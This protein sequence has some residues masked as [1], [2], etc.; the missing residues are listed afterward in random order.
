MSSSDEGVSPAEGVSPGE[1]ID[2]VKHPLIVSARDLT[3][4]PG[5]ERAGRCLADGARLI[6]NLLDAGDAVEAVLVPRGRNDQPAQQDLRAAAARAG[7]AVHE[8]RAGVLRHVLAGAAPP[9]AL[10]V[11]PLPRV[12]PGAVP[13]RRL[14]VVC[15]GVADPGN[16]GSVIRTAVG[17]GPAAVVL[18]GDEDPG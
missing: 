17:L 3:T 6:A 10:A 11:C 9:E 13:A 15:A 12:R 7:V 16:L 2:S 1:V 4:R 5:R 18:T 14:A 8:V